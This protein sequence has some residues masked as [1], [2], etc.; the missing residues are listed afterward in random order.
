MGGRGRAGQ[1]AAGVVG[2]EWGGRAGRWWGGAGQLAAGVMG[3]EFAGWVLSWIAFGWLGIPSLLRV[4]KASSGS[5]GHGGGVW[6]G[7]RGC[8]RR[9]ADPSVY[10]VLHW[11]AVGELVDGCG[12]AG[13]WFMGKCP[14]PCSIGLASVNLAEGGRWWQQPLFGRTKAASGWGCV[15]GAGT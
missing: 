8:G 6:K 5:F 1:L 11:M 9:V 15:C 3:G 14:A 13:G 7:R 10:M 12:G 4:C 2:G